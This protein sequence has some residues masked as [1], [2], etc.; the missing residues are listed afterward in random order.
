M[1]APQL[2]V[3]QQS[4]SSQF[5]GIFRAGAGA[6]LI[7]HHLVPRIDCGKGAKSV[8]FDQQQ[9][10]VHADKRQWHTARQTS[11]GG[12]PAYQH[13]MYCQVIRATRLG[14]AAGGTRCSWRLPCHCCSWCQLRQHLRRRCS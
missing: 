13:V 2:G 5:R 7:M 8:Y 6:I 11:M 12:R 10:A 3:R 4:C 14:R 1:A 9:V